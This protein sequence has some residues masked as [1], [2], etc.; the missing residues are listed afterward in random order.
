MLFRKD[1][2]ERRSSEATSA[3]LSFT[4]NRHGARLFTDLPS[5]RHET[6]DGFI[7]MFSSQNVEK[8]PSRQAHLVPLQVQ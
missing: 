8:K 6:A 7:D 5:R 3:D 4:S 2:D 1:L